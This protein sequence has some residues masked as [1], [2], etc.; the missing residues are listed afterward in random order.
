MISLKKKDISDNTPRKKVSLSKKSADS[1]VGRKRI[2]LAKTE[3]APG[4]NLLLLRGG[5][6]KAM[7]SMV[8]TKDPDA[9]RIAKAREVLMRRGMF[10]CSYKHEMAYLV[11]AF[12][13]TA[14]LTFILAVINPATAEFVRLF[15]EE[16]VYFLF[17]P[18]LFAFAVAGSIIT[19]GR[20]Y[21]YILRDAEMEITHPGGKK[22]YFYYSDVME[23]KYEE[24]TLFGLH[25]GYV[26]TI[27]TGVRDII[28]RY[29]F[30]KNKVFRGTDGSPFYYLEVN[31][32][33]T[34]KTPPLLD[35]EEVMRDFAM[36]HALRM[37]DDT[38]RRRRRRRF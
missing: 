36:Q 28:Y 9:A 34:E 8:L 15:P 4:V 11:A 12:T 27:S 6:H 24:L 29:I 23:I 1:K 38:N 30:G 35:S 17:I 16:A 3:R 5:R 21:R 2:S 7:P 22:E 37:Q 19:Y 13:G 18:I 14:L 10:R 31:S 26:V 32:G 20:P 33:L 25:R